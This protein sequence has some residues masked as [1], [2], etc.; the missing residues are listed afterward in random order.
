[1]SGAY[2]YMQNN[3]SPE[4]TV[5][6]NARGPEPSIVIPSQYWRR[7][8]IRSGF[9]RYQQHINRGSEYSCLVKFGSY[10]LNTIQYYYACGAAYCL[11]L[12]NNKFRN[13]DQRYF[14]V[15]SYYIYILPGQKV[16]AINIA[17]PFFFLLVDIPSQLTGK[18]T[19]VCGR[20]AVSLNRKRYKLFVYL[21]CKIL[22]FIARRH[23]I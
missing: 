10:G 19:R 17:G 22:E 3:G 14:F 20:W 8:L 6:C 16:S 4:Y 18:I 13:S 12:W 2:A 1:M 11:W 21:G 23:K 7:T 5:D 15:P 9:W